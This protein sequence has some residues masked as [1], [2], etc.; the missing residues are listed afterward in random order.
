MRPERAVLRAWHVKRRPA[1]RAQ[2]LP[3]HCPP[4]IRLLGRP[5]GTGAGGILVVGFGLGLGLTAMVKTPAT[6]PAGR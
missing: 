5:G 2:Q 4:A 6:T 3:W 1:E